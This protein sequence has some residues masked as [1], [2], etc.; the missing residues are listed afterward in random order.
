MLAANLADDADT[1]AAVAGQLAGAL[2][3]LTGIPERW[4]DRLAWKD[5]LLAEALKLL[6]DESTLSPRVA[7]SIADA[8]G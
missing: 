7:W 2:Y 8:D 1:V 3:G 4:I 5:R 6:A